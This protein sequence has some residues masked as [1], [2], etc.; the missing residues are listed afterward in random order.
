MNSLKY[1]SG[2]L[3]V[4][5]L[6]GGVLGMIIA[7]ISAF[8]YFENGPLLKLKQ[9][10]VANGYAEWVAD[11]PSNSFRLKKPEERQYSFPKQEETP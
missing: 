1:T 5:F 11:G 9:E 2:D 10:V 7:T 6:I 8:S 3:F 4:A